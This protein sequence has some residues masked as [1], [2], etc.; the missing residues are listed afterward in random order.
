MC[1]LADMFLRGSGVQVNEDKAQ[2]WLDKALAVGSSLPYHYLFNKADRDDYDGRLQLAEK[3]AELGDPELLYM[4][5]YSGSEEESGL[6]LLIRAAEMG[7]SKA[8]RALWV[9]YNNAEGDY[10][11]AQADEWYSRYRALE[12]AEQLACLNYRGRLLDD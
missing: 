11:K 6:E 2:E 8:A 4:L 9:Y 1:A 5:G 3:A 12:Q 10:N 7:H